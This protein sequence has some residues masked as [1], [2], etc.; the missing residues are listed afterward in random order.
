[1]AYLEYVSVGKTAADLLPVLA[2]A[3]GF[4]MEDLRQ[5]RKGR[6]SGVQMA[7][8]AGKA[9]RPMVYLVAACLV[10]AAILALVSKIA[11]MT[12]FRI[13]RMLGYRAPLLFMGVLGCLGAII[14][15]IYKTGKLTLGLML[16]V[17]SGR[18]AVLEGR[19]QPSK[20]AYVELGAQLL[21]PR[22]ADSALDEHATPMRYHY[23]IHGEY[24]EVPLPAFEAL[25]ARTNYRLYFAPHSKLLL[26]IEP[27]GGSA[28]PATTSP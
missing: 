9:V 2:K 11:P 10:W 25:E 19:V 27:L 23:V 1:M 7:R 28:S 8:M 18:A 6:I 14:A 16:D 13:F 5:N 22:T 15:T 4:A 24:F 3:N 26:S 17:V 20:E 21:R 12:Q